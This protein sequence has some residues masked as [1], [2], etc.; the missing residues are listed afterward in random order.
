MGLRK[1][2]PGFGWI[3]C[4]WEPWRPVARFQRYQAESLVRAICQQ[5][6][7]NADLLCRRGELIVGWVNFGEGVGN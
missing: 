6:N 3:V 5:E 1:Q 2:P 4:S 7:R